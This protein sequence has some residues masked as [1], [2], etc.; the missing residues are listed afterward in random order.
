L[1]G[2]KYSKNILSTS[3]KDFFKNNIMFTYSYCSPTH[4]HA[5]TLTR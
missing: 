3:S 1:N 2:K 5:H 4:T